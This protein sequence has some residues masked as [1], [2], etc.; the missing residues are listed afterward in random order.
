VSELPP[1]P[2]PPDQPPPYPPYPPYPPPPNQP[3]P[4]PAPANQPYFPP[5]YPYDPYAQQLAPTKTNGFSLAAL[6]LGIIGPLGLGVGSILAIIFGFIGLSQT[7]DGTQKGRGMAIAGLICAG[8]WI[9]GFIALITLAAIF[10][11]HQV[12]ATDLKVGDCV[13]ETPSGTDNKIGR[14]PKVSCDEPHQSEV[15]AILSVS[16]DRYP[17][18]SVLQSKYPLQCR[19]ALVTYAKD[20]LSIDIFVIYPSQ[21][22]WDNGNRDV[23]CLT[24]T[25]DKRTGSVKK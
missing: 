20:P 25:D 5:P 10:G 21:E 11:D 3:P 4:Y 16:G 12:R 15:Y 6:I 7:K 2:P 17:G 8:L 9:V 14:L 24:K 18:I 23:M 1:Y 13:E 19:Q 22:T